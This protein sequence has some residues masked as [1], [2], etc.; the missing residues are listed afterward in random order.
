MT[1]NKSKQRLSFLDSG[2]EGPLFPVFL[3]KIPGLT[4]IGLAVIMQQL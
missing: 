1:P 4:L 3:A 2:V